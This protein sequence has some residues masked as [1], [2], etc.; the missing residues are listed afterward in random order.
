MSEKKR[1]I[2]K[3]IKAVPPNRTGAGAVPPKSPV[4]PPTSEIKPKPPKKES[5]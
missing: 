4:T 1:E 2:P 3:V 5:K